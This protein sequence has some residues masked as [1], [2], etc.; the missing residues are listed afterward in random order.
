MLTQNQSSLINTQFHYKD[1]LSE[2]PFSK[3]TKHI[4]HDTRKENCCVRTEHMS[5]NL[6][7]LLRRAKGCSAV[8]MPSAST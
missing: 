6:I 2:I 7:Y 5:L 1:A 3:E 8:F 4:T